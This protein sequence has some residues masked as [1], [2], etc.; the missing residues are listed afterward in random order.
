MG[1]TV[2]SVGLLAALG[3]LLLAAGVEDARRRTISNWTNLLVA[4]LAPLWW[5][6]QGYQIWPDVAAQLLLATVVFALFAGV[7]ALGAMG[8]GDV[9]L[10]GALAL[11]LPLQPMMMLL[12]VMSLAGGGVTVLMMVDRRLRRTSGVVEVPYGVAIAFAGLLALREP[13]INQLA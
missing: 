6:S 12:L 2:L 1:G 13:I 8:G 4:A 3:L 11:W 10:I 7:F 9:K 5:W